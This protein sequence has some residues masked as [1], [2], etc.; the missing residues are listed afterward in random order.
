[1]TTIRMTNI[2]VIILRLP[3]KS[4]GSGFRRKRAKRALTVGPS[5]SAILCHWMM[6]VTD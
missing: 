3:N 4:S 1:M 6:L 2:F 5:E